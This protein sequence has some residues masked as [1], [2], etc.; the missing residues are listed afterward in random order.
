MT[1]N[2][3]KNSENFNIS[4]GNVKENNI[5][6]TKQWKKGE[7][8]QGYYYT[9]YTPSVGKL[10]V[11]IELKSYLIDLA[12][13][14][15]AETVEILAPVPSYEEWQEIKEFADYSL[16]NRDELTR[17]INFWMDKHTQIEKENQKLKDLLKECRDVIET[18]VWGNC[19]E[20]TDQIDEVLI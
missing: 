10:F 5:Y 2:K 12:K 17:Q 9:R 4:E 8:E 11:E 13:I 6:L 3:L 1:T 18:S 7:L 14:R 19:S 16:H 15:D 20:L